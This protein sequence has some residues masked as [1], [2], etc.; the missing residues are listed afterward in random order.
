MSAL[1]IAIGTTIGPYEITGW[2]GAGGMGDVYRARDGR[3][4]R[5]VAIKLIAA[6]FAGDPG[7][8]HRFEQEARAAGQLNHPNILVVYDAGV[9]EGAP[10]IV[11][12]LLEGESLRRRLEDGAVPAAKAI[13]L[14]RQAAEGL[15]AA[16]EKGITH[17]DVKPDNLF[18]TR[19]GR[20]KILDFGIAKLATPADNVTRQT[21]APTDT[22]AG[23]VVGTAG[24]MSPEQ[25]RGEQVDA[26][27][28]IFSLGTVLHE[29]LTGRPPFQRATAAETMAAILKE[30]PVE[31]LSPGVPPALARIIA[32]CLEKARE[33]R[34]QSARDLAFGLDVL[35]GT[36][37]TALPGTVTAA[38]RTWRAAVGAA[39]VVVGRLAAAAA[40][41]KSTTSRSFEQR[42]A[43]AKFTPLTNFDGSEVDAAISPDGRFVAFLAD[44]NGPFHVWLKQLNAGD[45]VDL[46]PGMGD[47]RNPGPNRSAG[48]IGD[49]SEI[50]INGT[51]G[52][53]MSKV[54]LTGGAPKAFL[55]EKTVNAAWAPN[56]ERFV[57]F[58]W[59]GDPL[60]V[61][62]RNGDHT[63]EILPARINDHNH[64][65][66]WSTDGEW[67][68][69][70]HASQSVAEYDVWRIRS[71]GGTPEQLTQHHGDLRY[72]TPFDRAT[73]LYVAPEQDGSGPWLWALDV[74]QRV[75]RRVGDGLNRYLSIAA[76]A[77]RRRLV[78]SVA[79]STAASLSSVPILDRIAE[80]SDVQPYPLPSARAS[81]PRF[82]NTALFYLSS[83]GGGDGLW[84]YEDGKS[85]ETWK[86]SDGALLGPPAVSPRGD[87]VV[88]VLSQQ[89]KR[90]LTL[91]SVEGG[92]RQSLAPGIDV[93]GNPSWS[94]DGK[95]IVSGGNDA[96]G[97]GLFMIPVPGGQPI[98]TVAGPAFDPVVSP[99][100][101]T[102]V[103][104]GPQSAFAPLLAVRSDRSPVT[105]P[106]IRV[107]T[108]GG[109]RS[110]F[111]SDGRL[112]YMQGSAGAQDFWVLDLVTQ[113]SRQLT[114]LSNPA[115]TTTFD[116]AP[117]GKH[118]VFDRVRERSDIVLI[119]LPK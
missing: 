15:A 6:T 62:D 106:A 84:R 96:E 98:R 90:L 69:Y 56:G 110:R 78:A 77:D 114:R 3:L 37:G 29:M 73:V 7:R 102:I 47:M 66:A 11:S 39:I 72:L 80:D 112:V 2:L 63:R 34:F 54:P 64:Y 76:S 38:P 75:T 9:H 119:D 24:Y 91:V 97:P 74:D 45:F 104:A 70:A 17:R 22:A 35:S 21:G 20:L 92:D 71:S 68:Y 105:L 118:I 100:G 113:T 4:G 46:T 81:A 44:R 18:I 41:L 82:G 103:Y 61:A 59:V 99:D 43:A 8:V 55:P 31:P 48:F 40:W 94:P 33:A 108:G 30:E 12:E 95:W 85:S 19:D 5:D 109:G 25:V 107:P 50:W 28:D 36:Q 86:G 16:H 83:T 57:Y 14:A 101:T 42:F 117:D 60:I 52:R 87:R 67:I 27:S 53:R 58:P 23:T 115:T 79:T 93:R 51:A 65:P 10:Y 49:G 1:P 89:G 88:L 116:I 13:D 32:R 111:L 26:R